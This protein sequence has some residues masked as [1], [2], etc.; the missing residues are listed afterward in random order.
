M[1]DRAWIVVQQSMAQ[2]R[3][4][5]VDSFPTREEALEHFSFM[6]SPEDADWRLTLTQASLEELTDL[7]RKLFSGQRGYDDA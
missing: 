7:V 5:I 1:E 4:Y 2:P 3:R 6:F